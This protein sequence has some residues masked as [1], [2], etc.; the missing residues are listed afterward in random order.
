MIQSWKLWL[1]IGSVIASSTES[2]LAQITPD[3]TLGNENSR[4]ESTGTVDNIN[5]GATRGTNLFHSFGE[6]N[7]REGRAAVF[8]NPTG[9]E[10]ILTRVTGGNPSNILG[11]LGVSGGNANL[12][13]MNPNGI[14]FG[15]NA[16]LDLR[17]S[18]VGTTANAVRLGDTGVFNASEPASSNL[19]TVRPS[20]LFFNAVA[21]Q[22]IVNRS[23]AQSLRGETNSIGGAVGLQV[24]QG[25]TLALV[26]GKV[27]FEG[28]NSTAARGRIELGSIAQN[29]T[30]K[31]IP[32]EKG[33]LLNYDGIQNF[34]DIQLLQQA[35]V[36]A[37]G[38]SG[39]DIQVRGRQVTLTDGSQ[40]LT[41]SGSAPGTLRVTASE[42]VEL[43]G[44]TKDKSEVATGLFTSGVGVTGAGGEI[45]VK[46]GRLTVKDG[47]AVSATSFSASGAAGILTVNADLVELDGISRTGENFS[48]LAAGSQGSGNGGNVTIN[49]NRLIVKNGAGVYI[50]TTGAG[51]GGVLTVNAVESVELIGTS[52]NGSPSILLTATLGSSGS[53]NAGSL[54]INTSRL[55]VAGGAAVSASSF[56][57]GE[58]GRLEVN[59]DFI[60]LSGT[61]S[62]GF[63][64]GLYA[65]NLSIGKAGNL[66][67]NTREFVIQN[68]ATVS[69]SAGTVPPIFGEVG[70]LFL[71]KLGIDVRKTLTNLRSQSLIGRADAGN[72]EISVR[73]LQL[74]EGTISA[75]TASGNGGN[76]N[77]NV[78]ELILLR[79]KSQISTSAGTAEAGG[80]GGNIKIDAPSGFVVA[81]VNENNDITANA[82]NG[83]GGRVTINSAGIF[84]ITVRSREDLVKLLGTNL[85]PQ[86]L[87]TN[88]ITAI[89]QTSPTLSGTV[90]L[91]I[92]NTDLNSGLVNVPTIPVDTEVAQ[93]CTPGRS[94]ANSEFVVTGRGGL[95]PT[96]TEALNPD[97]I[98]VDWVTL[99][100]EGKNN[101]NAASSTSSTTPESKPIV[102]AQGW[103]INHKGEV[104]LTASA[105]TAKPH[106]SWQTLANCP[107]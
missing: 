104:V 96:P 60:L 8:T 13:L 34:Q 75:T 85:D 64:S 86:Q 105:P 80:D 92:P 5:G 84:G 22:E 26:G 47:A 45:T 106:S 15:Q 88:D 49:T 100:P 89:S 14:I 72:L 76:I 73:F 103:I 55:I 65:D 3:T 46:T 27:L 33:W 48:N 87:P 7:V 44:T 93:A 53:K 19:L 52:S 69:V 40:L 2:G 6:F 31:L 57:A 99:Q 30:V 9:I 41:R 90:N 11:T 18:F 70:P 50:P 77:L 4:V 107:S 25:K 81:G 66:T 79:S 24:P 17:G 82:F 29:G 54:T 10:N 36:D 59:S 58:G 94:Q 74:D 68:G 67:I 23:Q 12:F 56:E 98:T 101:Y 1:L 42:S 51:E 37:S 35:I 62:Q 61:S 16:R 95:P 32:T 71:Q 83:S 20:A 102:E 28:G 63:S 97:A 21:A 39:G 43:I 38:G 78:R 91:N